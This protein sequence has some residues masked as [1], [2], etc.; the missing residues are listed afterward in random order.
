MA[1]EEDEIVVTIEGEAPVVAED[2]IVKIEDESKKTAKTNDDDIVGTLKA[3]LAEKQT[4]LE[5][6]SQRASSAEALV[7]QATQRARQL[8]QEVTEARTQA[9]ES[10]KNTIESSIAAAKSESQAAQD[11]LTSAFE[12]GDAKA[13]AAANRRIARAEADLAML[14]QAKVELPAQPQVRKVE[15]Q[16]T[17]QN[18][19]VEAFINS[20]TAPTA[21]WLRA[22]RDFLTDDTKRTKMDR[23]HYAAMGEGITLDS[24]EYFDFVER[25]LGLKEDTQKPS[26]VQQQQSTQQT[27][28]RPTA[29]VAPVTP[30]GGGMNG[31]ATEVRLTA[32]EAKSATDGTLVWNYDDPTGKGRFKKGDSIGIQEMARRKAALTKEG[33]Y[34]NIS[35]DGT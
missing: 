18:D 9:H 8:E 14:E 31:G 33:R 27:Q 17:N 25:K 30:S 5:A 32:A 22:H 29:P 21:N 16:P 4:A 2:T 34:Q 28:R 19:P 6:V 13:V 11:A 15:Q 10:T 35:V 23:A 1:G 3:Q 24:P 20:R 7:G 12:A 26:G